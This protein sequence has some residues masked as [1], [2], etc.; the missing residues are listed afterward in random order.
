[1]NLRGKNRIQPGLSF[2]LTANILFLSLLFFMLTSFLIVNNALDLN[3][4]DAQASDS[5]K[6]RAPYLMILRSGAYH[7][8]S[9]E[10]SYESI[11]SSL[12]NRLNKTIEPQ[13]I[14]S[15]EEGVVIEKVAEILDIARR[16][17]YKVTLVTR[18]LR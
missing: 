12:K 7:I 9:K 1:M 13:F 11:E 3:L 2:S 16:N 15:A 14:L 10:I 18:Y 6:Q 4:T 17:R 5:I 8:D